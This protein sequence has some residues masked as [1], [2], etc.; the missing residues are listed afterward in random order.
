MVKRLEQSF[1]WTA[2]ATRGGGWDALRAS[3]KCLMLVMF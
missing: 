2:A 1:I 3:E